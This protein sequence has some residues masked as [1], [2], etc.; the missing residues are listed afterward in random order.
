MGLKISRR[1]GEVVIIG[2]LVRMKVERVN[3]NDVQLYFE[4]PDD[5]SI[6]REEL[7]DRK[8]RDHQRAK[9]IQAARR[10]AMEL[11][12][13]VRERIERQPCRRDRV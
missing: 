10:S 12:I 11:A 5:I 6:D 7:H 13:T 8:E 1:V 4:A 2:G 9:A 3:G